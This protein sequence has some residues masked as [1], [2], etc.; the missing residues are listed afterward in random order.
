M[1]SDFSK[2]KIDISL[3]ICHEFGCGDNENAWRKTTKD[4]KKQTK[5]KIFIAT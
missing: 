4:V 3:D 2:Q 5:T 1:S